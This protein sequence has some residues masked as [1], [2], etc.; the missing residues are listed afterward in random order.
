MKVKILTPIRIDGKRQIPDAVIDV[1]AFTALDL[2]NRGCAEPVL[3]GRAPLPDHGRNAARL[4]GW[5][6]SAAV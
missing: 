3:T 2:V 5:V 1:P 4:A 6:S